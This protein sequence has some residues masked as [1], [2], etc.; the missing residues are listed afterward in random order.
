[1]SFTKQNISS[2]DFC[3]IEIGSYKL[4]L[5]AARL[6][7]RKISLLGYHEKRQDISYFS[8]NECLNVPGL[9][10]N[11]RDGIHILEEQIGQALPDIVISYPFGEIF[12]SCKHIHYKRKDKNLPLQPHELEEI[13]ETLEK[14]S[15]EKQSQEIEMHY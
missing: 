7:N 5:C 3:I 13:F 12:I 10:E 2:R 1:M 14:M 15:L 11:L 9:C 4:R 8:N 6:K